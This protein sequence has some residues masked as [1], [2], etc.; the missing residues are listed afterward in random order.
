MKYGAGKTYGKDAGKGTCSPM[1][2]SKPAMKANEGKD[3]IKYTG[4]NK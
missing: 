4:K 1:P 2:K 3:A